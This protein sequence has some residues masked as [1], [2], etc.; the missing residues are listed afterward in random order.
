[1]TPEREPSPDSQPEPDVEAPLD[2]GAPEADDEGH[3]APPL[4]DR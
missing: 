3:Q 2:E 4:D 1:M